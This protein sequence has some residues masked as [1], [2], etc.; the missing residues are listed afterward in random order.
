MYKEEHLIFREAFR[1]FLAKEI[2]PNIERWEEN[3]IVDREAWQKLGEQGFLCPWL[4]EKYGGSGADF[5]YSV[6]IAEEL[7][8]AGAISLMAPLHNLG[9]EEQKKKWLPG[10]A[11]GEY[12]LA[13]AMTEPNAGSDLANISTVARREEITGS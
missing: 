7:S 5:L 12:I 13:I 2:L 11:K 1:K 6:I 10:C 4:P 8:K 9:T 3:G